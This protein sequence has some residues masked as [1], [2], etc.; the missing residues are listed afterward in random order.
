MGKRP[1]NPSRLVKTLYAWPVSENDNLDFAHLSK[2][3]NTKKVDAQTNKTSK[4]SP[5]I[6]VLRSKGFCWFASDTYLRKSHDH[7]DT[8]R[9]DTAMYWSHAGKHFGIDPSGKWWG[10][11]TREQMKDYF[12]NNMAEYER[13]LKDDFVSEEFGD[14]RQEIVFIGFDLNEN[15]IRNELDKCLL[16]DDEMICYRKNLQEY[17]AMNKQKIEE[18]NNNY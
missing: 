6:G 15:D 5:F 3:K 12:I 18:Y 10:T 7:D 13:I 2:A 14:R 9:H 8:W 17:D 16:N 11:I 4:K 1:F